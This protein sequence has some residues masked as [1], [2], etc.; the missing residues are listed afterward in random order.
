MENME[1][2]NKIKQPPPDALK[3]ITGGRLSG[4]TDISPQWRLQAMTEQFGQ[5]GDDWYYEIDNLW[6]QDGI[7]GQVFAFAKI[8]LFTPSENAIP[9]IGGS[10]L[11][12]KQSGGLH[13]N[14][15]AFKM[16]VTD[17]LSVA[18]KA[19]GMGADVYA[20]K[21]DGTKYNDT[22]KEKPAP[23]KAKKKA[24]KTMGKEDFEEIKK[25]AKEVGEYDEDFLREF[26]RFVDPK[27]TIDICNKLKIAKRFETAMDEYEKHLVKKGEING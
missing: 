19:L 1:L 13:H 9:G 23:K 6:T 16:A 20:G 21:W 17:A 15:E 14:D 8:L 12:A 5:C 27:F 3:K 26:I 24:P 7:E 18:M 2:W 10:M 4:M 25:V 11:I 22:P